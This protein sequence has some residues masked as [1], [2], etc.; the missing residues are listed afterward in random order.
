MNKNGEP[1]PRVVE[2]GT[3]LV[4]WPAGTNRFLRQKRGRQLM[5][6]D[7]SETAHADS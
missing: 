7:F 4:T 3:H 6:H 5:Q 2:W 1:E